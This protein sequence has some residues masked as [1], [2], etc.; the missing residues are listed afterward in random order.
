MYSQSPNS[1]KQDVVCTSRICMEIR[2]LHI[3]TMLG[4]REAT[5]L[6]LAHNAPVKVKFCDGWNPLM[7]AVSYGDRQVM[8]EV[9]R[10]LKTQSRMGPSSRKSHLVKV[11]EDIGDLISN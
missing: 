9:L 4:Q 3:S 2:A 1:S 10:K 5:A 11:L 8:T 6:L 7:E